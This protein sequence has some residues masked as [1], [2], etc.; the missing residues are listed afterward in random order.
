MATDFFTLIR[1]KYREA[2]KSASVKQEPKVPSSASPPQTSFREL[3]DIA[4]SSSE[5]ESPKAE[6]T[7]E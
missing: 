4:V 3:T 1:T 7:E 6:V 2:E 5:P